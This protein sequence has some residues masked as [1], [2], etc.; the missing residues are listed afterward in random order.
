M[1]IKGNPILRAREQEIARLRLNIDRL[2]EENSQLRKLIN[3]YKLF[4]DETEKV[5][6]QL[7]ILSKE[8]ADFIEEM[9]GK[10]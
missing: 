4:V 8:L 7:G 10:L 9:K 2:R 5:F 6:K 1:N 3:R